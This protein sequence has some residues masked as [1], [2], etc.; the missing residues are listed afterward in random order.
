MNTRPAYHFVSESELFNYELQLF[1][2]RFD[3]YHGTTSVLRRHIGRTRIRLGHTYNGKQIS[4]DSPYVRGFA[5]VLFAV[6]QAWPLYAELD[7][8]RTASF[9]LRSLK[10][11]RLGADGESLEWDREQAINTLYHAV[12]AVVI[13]ARRL[14]LPTTCVF[15]VMR[16]LN[17]FVR[18]APTTWSLGND[19]H[20]LRH[21]EI[22]IHSV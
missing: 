17:N 7:D 22:G 9:F 8:H 5:Q 16:R 3:P 21:S 18:T 20:R 11:S 2:D 12:P 10:D 4:L 6:W 1:L 13:A 14:K 15:P 19:F